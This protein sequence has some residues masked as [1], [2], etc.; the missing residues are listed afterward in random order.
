MDVFRADPFTA[1]G[2]SATNTTL[3]SLGSSTVVDGLEC[4]D[5]DSLRAVPMAKRKHSKSLK[6]VGPRKKGVHAFRLLSPYFAPLARKKCMRTNLWFTLTSR[7]GVWKSHRFE[8]AGG[9]TG[10]RCRDS[11][12]ATSAH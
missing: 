4:T 8:T 10:L 5:G 2:L 9:A 12:T 7:T 3:P 11:R 6:L 1:M